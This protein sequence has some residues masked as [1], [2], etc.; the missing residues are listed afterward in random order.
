LLA[1]RLRVELRRVGSGKRMTFSAGESALSNRMQE[2][3]RVVWHVCEA[4][5]VAEEKLIAEVDLP[6]NL[7]QNRHHTFHAVLAGLR[8]PAKAHARELPVLPL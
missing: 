6:L 7:D 4:P 8:R 1:D 5:W 3:A 2:H